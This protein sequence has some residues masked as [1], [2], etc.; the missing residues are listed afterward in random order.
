MQRAV[1]DAYAEKFYGDYYI[2]TFKLQFKYFV[3]QHLK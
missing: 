2:E 1:Y 3:E